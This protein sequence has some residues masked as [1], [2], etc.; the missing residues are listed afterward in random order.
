MRLESITNNITNEIR[1]VD[2]AR[3]ND[4]VDKTKGTAKSDSSTFSS[5]AQRLS[6]TKANADIVAS[7]LE[8]EPEVRAEKVEE[9]RKKIESG[10]YNS[11]EFTDKLADKLMSDF[12]ISNTEA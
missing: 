11:E 8:V 7:R 12:G 9:V 6:E 5:N 1:K 3:R 2:S 4:K 10:Y